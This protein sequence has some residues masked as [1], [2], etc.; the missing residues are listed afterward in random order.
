MKIPQTQA[1]TCFVILSVITGLC[2]LILSALM[3]F[4]VLNEG[5]SGCSLSAIL[6]C[7]VPLIAS[8]LCAWAARSLFRN[9][10][11]ARLISIIVWVLMI[12]I[13]IYSIT[14]AIEV[15]DPFNDLAAVVLL[16]AEFLIALHLMQRNHDIAT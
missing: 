3:L 11:Q 14:A 7:L 5:W 16:A 9:V 12:P 1:G 6:G 8:G 10:T 13:A 4:F 2:G 15:R